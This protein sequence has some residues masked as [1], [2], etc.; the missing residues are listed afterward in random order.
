MIKHIVM[1]KLKEEAEGKTAAENAQEAK[2]R[3][4]KF[5]GEIPTLAALE[6]RLNSK[7]ANPANYD[8]ALICDF[9]DMAALQAYQVHPTHVAFGKFITPRRELRA[10]IDYAY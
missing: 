1:F 4:E 2:V 6:V 10:C 7:D 5:I 8:F 3:A 9:A